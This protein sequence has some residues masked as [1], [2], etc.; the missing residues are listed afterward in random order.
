M[1]AMAA[2]RCAA[3]LV[4]MCTTLHPRWVISPIM[5]I[6]VQARINQTEVLTGADEGAKNG[7]YI[8]VGVK[9]GCAVA[10]RMDWDCYDR[11]C[12]STPAMN[13]ARKDDHERLWRGKREFL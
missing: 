5:A 10:E 2:G 11:C 13:H 1:A 4:A 9:V 6:G 7:A 12:T 3:Q 8:P